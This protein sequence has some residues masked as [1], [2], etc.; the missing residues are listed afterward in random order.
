MGGLIDISNE[1]DDRYPLVIFIYLV[2]VAVSIRMLITS[3]RNLNYITK[4]K[5][6]LKKLSMGL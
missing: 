2:N 1:E 4:K 3:V 6:T 5:I